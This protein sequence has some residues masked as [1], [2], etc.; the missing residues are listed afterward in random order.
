MNEEN[1]NEI[2]NEKLIKTAYEQKMKVHLVLKDST[3]RNGFVMALHTGYFLFK[4][5]ENELESIFYLKVYDVKP[6]IEPTK[7]KKRE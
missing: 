4:D 1:L 5:T 7:I 6:Y 3:W 2:L